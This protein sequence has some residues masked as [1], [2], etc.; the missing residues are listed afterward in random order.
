MNQFTKLKDFLSPN[1]L[2][3][4]EHNEFN[5]ILKQ[6][7]ESCL[8]CKPSSPKKILIETPKFYVTYDDSPLIEG[9]VMIHSKVHYGCSGELPEEDFVEFIQIKSQLQELIESIYGVCSFYEH[10]RAGHCSILNSDV[11]C[12]HFHLHA[13]PLRA[14][15][16]SKIEN[17]FEEIT[18]DS[19]SLLH[20][21]YEQYDQYLLYENE[22]GIRFY[23]VQGEIPSHF[24]RTVIS[25]E[26]GKPERADWQKVA[27]LTLINNLKQKVKAYY[28]SN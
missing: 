24:L 13:L 17:H 23:P 12:E 18:L 16:A 21:Y 7:R 28:E 15:I 1:A 19:L 6:N 9:H 4:I 10:G 25:E 2:D 26:I 11:L 8:F 22:N 14:D 3:N 27:D 5:I 20:E